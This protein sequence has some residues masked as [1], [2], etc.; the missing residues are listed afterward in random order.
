MEVLLLLFI[1][2]LV[3]GYVRLDARLTALRREVEALRFESRAEVRVTERAPEPEAPPLAS[4][5]APAPAPASRAAALLAEREAE[6]ADDPA[7]PIRETLGAL[8]ERYVGGRLLIWAGGIALAVAGIFLVRF[9]M[10]VG[11]IGPAVQMSLAALF[12]LLLI[13]LAEWARRRPGALPDP[14]VGQSLAG[15]GIFVLYAAAYGGLVLHHLYGHGTAMTLMIAITGLALA[16]SLRHGAPTAVMGLAGGFATPLL[17]GERHGQI[18]PLLFYLGL[19]DA[20]L[21]GLAAR[22]GWTWLAAA[23]VLLSFG[24]SAALLFS[25]PDDALATGLFV[26]VLAVGASLPRPGEGRQLAFLRPAALGVVQLALLVGRG[27]LGLP[28]WGLFASLSLAAF[29]LAGR[30]GEYRPIPALAL[31]AALILLAVKALPPADPHVGAI[32]AGIALLFAAGAIAALLRRPAE[33]LLWTAVASIAF[34]GPPILLR[35]L[36]PELLPL[37]AWGATFAAAAL[38][39]LALALLRRLVAAEAALLLLGIAARDLVPEAFLPAAWLVLGTGAALAAAR[40]RDRDL[41]ILAYAVAAVATLA[42]IVL[43]PRL[44]EALAA[45]LVGAA[46]LAADLPPA[47]RALETLLLP[48]GLLI[49]VWRVAPRRLPRLGLAL[50]AA[51]A[52]LAVAGVYIL[53]KQAWG[54]ASHDD[55]LA[56]GFAERVLITQSLFALGWAACSGRVPVPGLE[57]AQRRTLGT[58]L[59]ALAAARFAWFDLLVASPLLV[60]FR[61]GA[62][63]FANLLLP[64][65][66]LSAFWLYRARQGARGK[67]R[68]GL[69]LSLSLVALVAGTLLLVRQGFHGTIL[70]TPGV[71]AT[72]SYADSLAALL[73]SIALLVAGIRIPDKAVRL[74]GLLLLSATAAKV[75][76]V[77]AAKLEGVLRILSFLGLGIALIG[78]GKLYGAVL[79]AEA[80]PR[81]P[82]DPPA[83]ATAPEARA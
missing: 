49:L 74:A 59:T 66:I 27:D 13:A 42:G 79:N 50:P 16:L 20:A 65:Y 52:A 38:G 14:R 22:R 82:D 54:L 73:L 5:L 31:A 17:V 58:G 72:E 67:G 33:A 11:L 53:F 23:A 51:A 43:V 69:W 3:V 28:A 64:A 4:G 39:P 24:W 2:G 40:L 7:P 57:E 21:F 45:S 26:L 62:L 46:I 6:A 10:Q 25:T 15:A 55:Y 35:T 19:L 68:S 48:A 41:T 70:S 47:L 75:F 36:R 18:I 32:G 81:A 80:G 71:P 29:V 8:F 9:S 12:G 30:A 61:V 37:G 77:D 63:P 60:E 34:A 44:W 1:L 76:L 83:P 56:R 78:I